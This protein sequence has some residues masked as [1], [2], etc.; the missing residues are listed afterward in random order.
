MRPARRTSFSSMFTARPAHLS[1][2]GQELKTKPTQQSVAKLRE[3]G[4]Q[5]HM[6]V[7]RCDH[8]LDAGLRDKLSLFCNVPPTAVIEC[9]DVAHSIYE[10]PLAPAAGG[11]G[12]AG[13]GPPRPQAAQA[14]EEHLGGDRAPPPDPAARGHDRRRRQVHRAAGRLQVGLR[15]R[16]PRGHRQPLPGERPPDRRRGPREGGRL[17]APEGPGRHP[18]PGR[19]RRPRH[20]G[21]DSPRPATPAKTRSPITA[22]ALGC[23]SR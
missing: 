1:A 11:H 18:R 14:A 5:P 22:S 17:Q 6:L 19:V 9:R 21:Q 2:A 16:H 23:R 8:P 7:C 3:I 4:I 15:G 12:R 13:A 20:G 10:L